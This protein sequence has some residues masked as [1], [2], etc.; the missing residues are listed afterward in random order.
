MRLLRTFVAG[1]LLVLG[2]GTEA[3]AVEKCKVKIDASGILHVSASAVTGGLRWGD[4]ADAVTRSF[5]DPTCVAGGKAK[6][7]LLADP[8]TVAAR[9]PPAGCTLHLADDGPA[10]CSAWIKGCTPGARDLDDSARCARVVN[11]I[12]IFDGCQ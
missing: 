4:A 2:T 11:G 8:A 3:G 1:A 6:K 7:C 12:T 5:F 9:T 10:P